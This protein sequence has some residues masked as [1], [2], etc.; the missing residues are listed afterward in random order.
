MGTPRGG[1]TS[2][3][4]RRSNVRTKPGQKKKK[5]EVKTR[6]RPKGDQERGKGPCCCCCFFFVQ[7]INKFG[8]GG[9]KKAV[10]QEKV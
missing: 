9:K 8:F 10:H 7:K 5:K 6:A 3:V 2:L 1:K 4:G